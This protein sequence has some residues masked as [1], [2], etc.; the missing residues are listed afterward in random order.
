METHDSS[1]GANT[2]LIVIVIILLLIGGF[3]F[4][5][6]SQGRNASPDAMQVDVNLPDANPLPAG[7]Q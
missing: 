2:V 6:K 7:N 3:I 1:S 4:W 5:N